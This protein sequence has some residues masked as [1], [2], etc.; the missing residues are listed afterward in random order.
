MLSADLRHHLDLDL[1]VANRYAEATAEVPFLDT[2]TGRERRVR[3]VFYLEHTRFLPFL[4]DRK[5]RMSMRNGLRVRLP[6]CDHRLV[7]YLWNIP[8]DLKRHGGQE[9]GILRETAR[10]W[11]PATVAKRPKSG[12]PFGQSEQYLNA[13]REAVREMLSDPNAP[14]LP[15]LNTAALAELASGDRWHSGTFTP[16]PLLPRALMLNAW[17]GEYGVRVR[18]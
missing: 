2:E 9:K 5:D 10:A 18:L 12:F 6:F 8:W 15:L 13:V 16:P 4:L 7:E 3:E 11:L 14:A 17:L 1:A